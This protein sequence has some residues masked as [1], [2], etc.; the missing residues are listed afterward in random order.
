MLQGILAGAGVVKGLLDAESERK[1]KMAQAGSDAAAIRFSPWSGINVGNLVG[2]DYSSQDPLSGALAGGASGFQT[3]ANIENASV[4]KDLA[5]AK[6]EYYKS[7]IPISN[8]AKATPYS[9]LSTLLED[10]DYLK[11]QAVRN[12]PYGMGVG[13]V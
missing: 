2:R 11:G 6:A 9:D 1:R 3:G 10:E 13:D 8:P 5:K 4:D 7:K 12:M